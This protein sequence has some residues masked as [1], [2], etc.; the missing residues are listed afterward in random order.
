MNRRP[1]SQ[2]LVS[3]INITPFTDV[4]LV[5]LIIFMV[6]TPL[7]VQ[8][9][10]KIQLPQT[11]KI[12]EPPEGIKVAINSKGEASLAGNKYNIR[13]DLEL[14]KFKLAS[15]AKNPSTATIV[16]SGDK[17]VNYE[18]VIKVIDVASQLGIK[19]IALATE[20]KQ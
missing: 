7:I 14:L 11:S 12:D 9:S 6:A 5:L 17:N 10:V 15:L 18:F 4:I 8:S 19:H 20:L 3:E 16:I 2:K 1:R 13:F